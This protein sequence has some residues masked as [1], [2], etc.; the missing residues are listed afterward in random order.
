MYFGDMTIQEIRAQIINDYD[1]LFSLPD[2]KKKFFRKLGNV[3]TYP[4]G[5]IM[6]VTA[7]SKNEYMVIAVFE[8][9][10]KW[11]ENKPFL[12]I[13]AKA[14]DSNSGLPYPM[15]F[16][17]LNAGDVLPIRFKPHFFKRYAQ[18][19]H[20]PDNV[21]GW[22]LVRM[23]FARNYMIF[24]LI[25]TLS[26]KKIFNAFYLFKDGIGLGYCISPE[27]DKPFLANTFLSYND[28]TSVRNKK[29]MQLV[30]EL[31][32]YMDKFEYECA[33]NINKQ[34]R[35]ELVERIGE[36]LANADY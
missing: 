36:Q 7:P 32:E 4:Y 26:K 22:D 17:D 9:R 24:P 16:P 23:F 18:R 11:R 13:I 5:Y 8:T 35:K 34:Y 21:Q 28:I 1:Y 29:R 19:C 15:I 3:P 20:L 6:D 25:D 31:R 33:S 10:K 14:I 12:H 2:N 30:Q 27:E